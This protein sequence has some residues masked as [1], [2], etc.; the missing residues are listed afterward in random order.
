MNQS[1]FQKA[2]G[3]S[4]PLYHQ[5]SHSVTHHG[6]DSE[7]HSECQFLNDQ[8]NFLSWPDFG[9]IQPNSIL[10]FYSNINHKSFIAQAVLPKNRPRDSFQFPTSVWTM[11]KELD[12]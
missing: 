5:Q 3:Y 7:L 10:V 9:L 4:M 11:Y 6:N 1:S 8:R 12:Y 2:W